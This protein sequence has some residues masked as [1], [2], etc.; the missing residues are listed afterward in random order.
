MT[1]FNLTVPPLRR[2][3][4]CLDIH[5]LPGLW[6]VHLQFGNMTLYSTF[7]TQ[8]DRACIIWSLISVAIFFT[9]QFFPLDW[10]FQA[11]LW[12]VLTLVGTVLM[13]AWT[14]FWVKEEGVSWVLYFWVILMVAGLVITDLGIYLSWGEVLIRLCD[15]WLFLSAVGYVCTGLA[16]RSRA[17]ILVGAFHVLCMFML[18]LFRAWQFL[19][20]GAVQAI[21]LLVLAQWQW[22]MRSHIDGLTPQHQFN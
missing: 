14:R 9:A 22:D 8:V 21:G 17:I 2:K 7:Y 11:V 15:L 10:R 4:P 5:E 13:V 18:P 6:C 1:F 3:Q 20:T 19:V 16:V 12:S